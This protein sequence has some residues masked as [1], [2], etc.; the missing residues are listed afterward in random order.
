MNHLP[1]VLVPMFE[2]EVFGGPEKL[3]DA[4][5]RQTKLQ[6][7][8]KQVYLSRLIEVGLVPILVPSGVPSRT[9]DE[10]YGI[11]Q[12]VLLMGGEDIDPAYYGEAPHP[13]TENP[14]VARDL[15]ELDIAR[16]A[17]S[18]RRPVLGICRG[19]QLL[20]VAS[21]GKLIQHLPDVVPSE[22]HRPTQAGQT[23]HHEILIDADSK[24][25]QL[26][27]A[28]KITLNSSHHQ[29]VL[30]VGSAMRISGR[31]AAGVVEIIE[32]SDDSEAS[33]FLF[34]IQAH[35]E[36][37]YSIESEKLFAAFAAALRG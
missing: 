27:G 14:S 7:A 26:F 24:A 5:K 23:I 1:R 20:A 37:L 3:Q 35:P 32:G 25:A 22:C 29:A 12:G 15:L 33:P 8:A 19:C 36:L 34:G 10:L 30:S 17:V 4:A 16:R 31:T 9:V 13:Q 28:T 6:C 2:R 18:D 21:G 11:T